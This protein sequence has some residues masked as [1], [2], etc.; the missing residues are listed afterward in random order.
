MQEAFDLDRLTVYV[1][2]TSEQGVVDADTRITFSQ[3]GGR[4]LGRYRGGRVRRG[5]L[6]GGVSGAALAFRYLQV[7]D[8]GEIHGGRSRCEISRTPEGRLR[9]LERFEWTTRMGRGVNVF[10]ELPAAGLA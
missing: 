10:D 8:S 5:V 6:V 7:E 3:R 4:V 9:I 1:S 2:S